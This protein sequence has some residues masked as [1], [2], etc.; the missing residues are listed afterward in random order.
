[1]PAS[2]STPALPEGTILG[3]SATVVQF[4]SAFCQPCRAT[5]RTVRAVVDDMATTGVAIT[6]AAIDGRMQRVVR[7]WE[8]ALPL[9][10]ERDFILA[11]LLYASIQL[12]LTDVGGIGGQH[13]SMVQQ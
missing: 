5:R 12:E 9:G 1:M 10:T 2:R 8:L 6:G 7:W 11:V 3:S 4:S 13:E